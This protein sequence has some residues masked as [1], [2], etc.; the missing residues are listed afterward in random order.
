MK[1]ATY[2]DNRHGAGGSRTTTTPQN[3]LNSNSGNGYDGYHQVTGSS[4]NWLED[5][6]PHRLRMEL[7]RPLILAADGDI[8]AFYDY[9]VKIWIDCATCSAAELAQFKDVRADFSASLPQIEKTINRGNS[10]KIDPAD[11]L[12]L[13]RVLFGFTQGTG[14]ATQN[15]TLRNLELYFLKEYPVSYPAAW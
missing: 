4:P 1:R 7:I 9:Q 2:D 12:D 3:S 14:G 5:G 6:S 15:I 8:D 13:I 10:L 11:H